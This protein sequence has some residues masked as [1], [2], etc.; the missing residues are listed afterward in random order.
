[1]TD[2]LDDGDENGM[3][4]IIHVQV[5]KPVIVTTTAN[6]ILI[7]GQEDNDSDGIGDVCDRMMTTTASKTMVIQRS[8]SAII[9]VQTVKLKTVTI[10]VRT[11]QFHATEYR[12]DDFGEVC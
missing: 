12:R 4:E 1:M 9:T 8:D 10:T 11:I 7:P 6:L 5:G 2:I 3:I